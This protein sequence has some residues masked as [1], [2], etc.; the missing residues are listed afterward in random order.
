MPPREMQKL[1]PALIK[2]RSEFGVISKDAT[3]PHYKSKYATL[4]SVLDAVT[5]ALC[6]NGL[7][8]V[9]ATD[10]V[11]GGRVLITHLYHES[12]EGLQSRYPLPA[13]DDPQKF[14]AALTYARRY[15]I[16]ALL[17]ITADEDDDGDATRQTKQEFH[18]P[19]HPNQKVIAEAAEALSLEHGTVKSMILGQNKQRAAELTDE[20]LQV[21]VS[22]MC[23]TW[24]MTRGVF[25]VP[26]EAKNSLAKMLCEFESFPSY[27]Q[28]VSAWI[29]KVN[30]KVPLKEKS[31]LNQPQKTSV[32]QLASP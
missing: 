32:K 10:L 4:D 1:L 28:I 27:A 9:Q 21:V 12:G 18:K 11:E 8:V 14:G 6:A 15:A 31:F 2:A 5:P 13:I 3:N 22:Q 7:A 25:Q 26:Q 29:G 23:V 16:C 24:G 20:E 17:S 30:G 19:Q